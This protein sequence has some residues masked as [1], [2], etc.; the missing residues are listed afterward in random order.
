MERGKGETCLKNAGASMELTIHADRVS[1]GITAEV[2]GCDAESKLTPHNANNK[3]RNC[4]L[5]ETY[6]ESFDLQSATNTNVNM[7][8]R[9]RA[10][11]KENNTV[12]LFASDG[13][14]E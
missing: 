12:S 3:I 5:D 6:C 9:Y 7:N 11:T 8:D 14:R 13:T 2:K 10:I 4:N 1:H